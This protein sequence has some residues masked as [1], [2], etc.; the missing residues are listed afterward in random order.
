MEHGEKREAEEAINFPS[1]FVRSIS[2]RQQKSVK[3]LVC[4]NC[5][6]SILGL[7]PRKKGE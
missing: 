7:V 2:Q 1:S 6:A 3:V 4:V 5:R